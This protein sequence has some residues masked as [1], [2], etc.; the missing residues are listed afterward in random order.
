MKR[1][2]NLVLLIGSILACALVTNAQA[3]VDR[4]QPD[5]WHGLVIDQSTPQD[6]INLLGKPASDKL[7][8]VD[9]H[10][11]DKWITPRHKEKIFRELTFKKVGDA[12]KVELSFL[13]DRL[14]V[15][16]L[17]Y[18]KNKRR[19]REAPAFFGTDFVLVEAIPKGT[20]PADYEGQ[21]ESTV[22][23]VYPIAY[24]MLSVS[25]GSILLVIVNNT[26]FK[27]MLKD[28][29]RQPTRE[30]WPGWVMIVEIISRKLEKTEAAPAAK[31]E[32]R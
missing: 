1:F 20:R 13:E 31:S 10:G 29:A 19:A 24:G 17:D 18:D 21:K 6:A 27:A 26:G 7:D 30:V 22:P 32:A 8:S 9:I 25:R 5:G 23:K 3:T 11:V 2:V 15:I 14:A 28:M 12:K 4:A 16:R